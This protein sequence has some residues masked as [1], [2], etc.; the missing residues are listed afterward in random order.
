VLVSHDRSL[1]RTVCDDFLLVA[2]GKAVPFDGDL[3]DYLEWLNARRAREAGSNTDTQAATD[4]ASRLQARADTAAD[5]QAKLQRRRPLVKELEK[6]EGKLAKLQEEKKQLDDKLADSALYTGS[7]SAQVPALLKRQGE[8]AQG[9]D[10][11]EERWLEIQA[12]LEEI[13]EL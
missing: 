2:D 4:K 10:E 7:D 5:R 9:V 1:L 11:A 6:L 3:D 8:L 13:G 12:E